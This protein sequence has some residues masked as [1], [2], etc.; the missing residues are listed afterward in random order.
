[1]ME[2]SQRSNVHREGATRIGGIAG[3]L[4]FLGCLIA[5]TAV[6]NLTP[7]VVPAAAIRPAPVAF[8]A[9][10]R[11]SVRGGGRPDATA[12]AGCHGGG[13]VS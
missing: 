9:P 4:A 13:A 12:P 2:L 7:R 6:A 10:G 3:R 1:M 8:A 5:A 11:G